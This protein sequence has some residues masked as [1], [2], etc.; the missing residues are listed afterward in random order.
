MTLQ[1][2]ITD[3]LASS[4]EDQRLDRDEKSEVS[5]LLETL[6]VDE[7]RY[8][9]NQAFDL[10]QS[11]I[12]SGEEPLALLRW[13]ERIVKLVDKSYST[14]AVTSRVHFS[15][16]DACRDAITGLLNRARRRVDIC[17]FTISD[18]RITEA[19]EAVY[20]RGISVRIISDN[21][22]ANDR[23]SDIYQ[24]S[25]QGV[26]VRLD[27]SSSH[28]HHKFALVDDQL[29]NGSFNW[30]RSATEYNQENIVITDHPELIP[31]F[32]TMF[33]ELWRRFPQ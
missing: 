28:M 3:L 23:G 29:I 6:D 33:N 5:A 12:R 32:D 7:K 15:P 19:I 17:V 31:R 21:D 27:V 13:L 20:K 2:T 14:D 1:T 22:K 25:Q 9:R 26:P 16:G 4:L 11:R 18:N 10:V 30:T 24:L 8:L